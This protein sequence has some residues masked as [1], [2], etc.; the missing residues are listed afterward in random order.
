MYVDSYDVRR[1]LRTRDFF[2]LERLFHLDPVVTL[3]ELDYEMRGLGQVRM[4][5][6]WMEE[7]I[8]PLPYV[9]WLAEQDR[10][11]RR[12]LDWR[13][14]RDADVRVLREAYQAGDLGL[15]LGAGVSMAANMPGWKDLVTAVLDAA[16]THR[17]RL[18]ARATSQ[19]IFS[20]NDKLFIPP[21]ETT[22]RNIVDEHVPPL[23]EGTR[24]RLEETRDSLLAAQECDADLL[25][26]AT[27]LAHEALGQD[28]YSAL[29]AILFRS[30]TLYKTEIHPAIVRM[31]RP[32]NA[33][34]DKPCP[35]V[36]TVITYNFD[37]LLE[38]VLRDTDHGFTVELSKQGES[39]KLWGGKR[40]VDP[41]VNI[42]HVHGFASMHP[43]WL[44]FPFPETD[45]IFTEKQYKAKY[46][47]SSNFSRRVQS[48]FFS[49]APGLIIGSS[50]TDTYA[51]SELERAH[52]QR[53][54]WCNYCAMLIP[55]RVQNPDRE[56]RIERFEET[57]MRYRRM[58]VRVIWLQDYGELPK[59][60]DAIRE[61]IPE[62]P[63]RAA[64]ICA[65]KSDNQG[66][67]EHLRKLPVVPRANFNL[68]VVL[69]EEG[70]YEQAIEAYERAIC[71]KDPE[72][73]AKAALNVSLLLASKDKCLD[74][75]INVT[76][77]A[78]SFADPRWAASLHLCA[79]N[80]HVKLK[81]NVKAQWHYQNAKSLS[82]ELSLKTEQMLREHGAES[83]DAQDY[84]APILD[85]SHL[86]VGRVAMQK[87]DSLGTD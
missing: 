13:Q 23:P 8:P 17:E 75:A 37:D 45:L 33:D 34:P 31:I 57:C 42:I 7:P 58:G 46:G 87:L 70:E 74:L 35:R 21:D 9:R 84:F 67:K 25:L 80:I 11:L 15:I 59:L 4:P 41:S 62:D 5:W 47:D 52:Q 20:L 64:E 72:W 12:S 60:L 30:R 55:E 3:R 65:L 51:V 66:V 39:G 63:L 76:E 71:S 24:R 26:Q 61:P 54:G 53:P 10:L 81:H 85:H 50:L 68:G 78:L 1:S 56:E 6:Q 22:A 29:C 43:E 18:I 82:D 36:P 40:N 83:S 49:N 77:E 14:Q 79:G 48:S 19:K 73:G 28:F 32:A 69:S 2:G 38:Q 44:G 16:L 27:D 86:D